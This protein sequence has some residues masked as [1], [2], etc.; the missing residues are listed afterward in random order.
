MSNIQ[1]RSE[2][3]NTMVPLLSKA[4]L[5]ITPDIESKIL[6]LG[7]KMVKLHW[8]PESDQFNIKAIIDAYWI[9]FNQTMI[10]EYKES[11]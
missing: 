10:N 8:I 5:T 9:E 4:Q 7:K 3:I 11:F 1:T 6:P 2:I